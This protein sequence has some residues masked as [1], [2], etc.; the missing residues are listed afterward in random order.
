MLN[1]DQ[2]NRLSLLKTMAGDELTRKEG[3]KALEENYWDTAM[4]LEWLKLKRENPE[5]S[6]DEFHKT[7][8]IA[9]QHAA[10]LPQD[11]YDL[12]TSGGKSNRKQRRAEMKKA[13][14]NKLK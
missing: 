12:N 14:K 3:I 4:A 7:Y 1:K 6:L 10:V 5:A 8:D 11:R 13:K 9:R 2:R